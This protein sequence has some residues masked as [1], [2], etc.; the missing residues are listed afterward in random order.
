MK[1]TITG[2]VALL[3]GAFVAHSQGTVSMANYLTLSSYIYVSMKGGANLG[4]HAGSTSGNYTTDIG[5]GND[6][7]VALYGNAGAGDAANTLTECTVAGGGFAVAT[8]ASGTGD[9]TAGTWASSLIAQVPGTTGANQAATLQL[10][11]WYNDGGTLT[12]AQAQAAGDPVGTSALANLTDTGG[13]NLLGGPSI[14]P[15]PLPGGLTSFTVSPTPE[16]STI[17]LGVMGA[18]A[19]LLRLRRKK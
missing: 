19:F 11:A 7:S 18:S 16:P 12:Y 2:A 15:P 9:S 17:A 10:Y 1:K 3:A 5:N 14:T 4:G 6:W 8:L 13:N